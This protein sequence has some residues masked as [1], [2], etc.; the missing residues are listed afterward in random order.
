MCLGGPGGIASSVV[1]GNLVEQDGSHMTVDV[2][3]GIYVVDLDDSDSDAG[4][5]DDQWE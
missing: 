3:D 2:L 1:V 4:F 5:D